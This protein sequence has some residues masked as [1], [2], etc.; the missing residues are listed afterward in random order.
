MTNE[1]L[2]V[3]APFFAHD[4]DC[5]TYLGSIAE[6]VRYDFYKCGEE[7]IARSGDDG[8]EY[9][10]WGREVQASAMYMPQGHILRVAMSFME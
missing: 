1:I 6:E 2:N 9:Q 4:C 3:S 5:C 10:A 8:P 7:L